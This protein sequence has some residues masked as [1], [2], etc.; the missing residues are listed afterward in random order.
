VLEIRDLVVHDDRGPNSGKTECPSMF[1][2]GEILAARRGPGQRSDRNSSK[3]SRVCVAWSQARSRLRGRGRYERG[4]RDRLST[5]GSVI[6]P[7]TVNASVS[8]C[9][10]SLADKSGTQYPQNALP[11]PSTAPGKTCRRHRSERFVIVVED[12]RHPART[13]IRET[14]QFPLSGGNQQKGDRRTR[15][16]KNLAKS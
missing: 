12:F 15:T 3:R 11:S 13:S 7:K 1:R 8:C 4:R 5:R 10:M 2:A 9:P 6:S 16:F 14:R